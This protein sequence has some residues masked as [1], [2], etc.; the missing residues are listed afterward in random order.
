MA[1]ALLPPVASSSA[2]Q[3]SADVRTAMSSWL[4]MLSC[5]ASSAREALARREAN[6]MLLVSLAR[7]ADVFN[8]TSA[9]ARALSRS[10][11]FALFNIAIVAKADS[12][13][14]ATESVK[15]AQDLRRAT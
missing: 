6:S 9:N 3:A 14:G 5:V 1:Q 4:L 8:K 15:V 12:Y 10:A 2:R 11:P 13:I 7:W